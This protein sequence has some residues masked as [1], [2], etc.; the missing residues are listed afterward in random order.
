LVDENGWPGGHPLDPMTVLM[1]LPRKEVKTMWFI[2]WT[3]PGEKTPV[4]GMSRYGQRM[5]AEKQVC[6]F[7]KLFPWNKYYIFNTDDVYYLSG[8]GI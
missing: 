1:I 2:R 3:R 4:D 8:D 7:K 5:E 6:H